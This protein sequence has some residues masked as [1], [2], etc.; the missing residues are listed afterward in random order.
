MRRLHTAL[1]EK[2][3]ESRFLVG[4]TTDPQ[5]PQVHLISDEVSEY[6]SLENGVKSRIGYRLEKL[7]G[8]HP[9]S[10]R[11][12]LELA[13][14]PLFRWADIVD[15]RNLFGRYFN[16]WS[17]PA[18]SVARPI[19]W[20]L[21]DLWAVTGHCAYPY[22]CQRWKT[23]CHHCPL[24]TGEGRKIVEPRPTTRDGTR[25][26]WRAKR[27]LYGK[28]RLHIIVTTEW[29]RDNV[30]Q[31]ILGNALSVNVISNGVNLE[32]FK[33]IS[34][35][36]ARSRLGLPLDESCLLWA[37]A[38]KGSY[39]KGFHLVVKAMEQIQSRGQFS[40]TLLTMGEE[41]G[42]NLPEPL[43][44]ARHFGFVEDA[45]KQALIYAAADVF[46]C[47]TLADG[48]PQTALESLATGTPII[49]F[50][51]GPMPDLAI[52]GQTGFLAPARTAQS[53]REAIEK[54]L[55][56][57]DLHPAMRENSRKQALEKY[58]IGKQTEKYIELYSRVLEE[59]ATTVPDHVRREGP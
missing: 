35:L 53:L 42:W 41:Q 40:P 10:N 20:R 25:R 27:D 29:M 56:Q 12:M 9:W 48:Q 15:L 34:R 38:G 55:R 16:L 24:L 2:N 21:P 54:F 49:A 50:D 37:A 11:A 17:L 23:G 47:S 4:K 44:K 57:S 28:A 7:W 46:L 14:T 52:D 26:V 58:D 18:L 45:S 5:D 30:R 13:N 39:R 59:K 19:V 22:D 36:E 1:I 33:P 6:R 32:V 3:H 31:S 8:I 51:V 43:Q